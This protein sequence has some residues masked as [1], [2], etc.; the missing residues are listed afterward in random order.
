MAGIPTPTDSTASAR[1]QTIAVWAQ[2][3]RLSPAQAVAAW[4]Q[5]QAREHGGSLEGRGLRLFVDALPAVPCPAV[6]GAASDLGHLYETMLSG[7]VRKR[8][9]VH[10]TP[11]DIAGRLVGLLQPGW[12]RAG[13]GVLDP[14]VGGGAFLIAAADALVAAGIAPDTALAG[15][16]G[17]DHDSTAVAVAE[18]ALAVWQVAHDL[19]PRPLD[20]LQ[21]GDGLLD[22][23]PRC[24]IAVGNPP[25]LNQLRTVSA[26]SGTRRE[27]LRERWGDLMGA[28]TDEAW[29]F[30]AASLDAVASDGQLV[31]VQP[32]SVLAARHSEAVRR[33]LTNDAHLAGLW[34]SDGRVFDASV[35]VCAPVLRRRGAALETSG[36]AHAVPMV[37]RWRGRSFEE[38]EARPAPA[39]AGEWGRLGA[40]IAGI[41]DVDLTAASPVHRVGRAAS[42]ATVGTTV[43]DIASVTAGFRDQFYGLVPFVS[44][45]GPSSDPGAKQRRLATVGMIDPFR[46]RWGTDE[47]RF[48]G[49]RYRAPVLDVEKLEH[50]DP[51]LGRWVEARHRPKVLIATQTKVL[52]AWVDEAGGVVP[53]TPTI[54]LEPLDQHDP[55]QLWRLLAL[56]MAPAVSAEVAASCFGTALSIRALKVSARDIASLPL[57]RDRS[58]WD[59]GAKL[60]RSIQA[61][62]AADGVVDDMLAAFGEAMMHAFGLSSEDLV[63]WWRAGWPK[64]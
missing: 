22:A 39:A 28:Y 16:S 63:G 49:E 56:L 7:A 26:N 54:S 19:D 31:M 27:A 17:I 55:E 4:A 18:A 29:L 6:D 53:A 52:E 59:L 12:A 36:A 10:L 21:V 23:L 9:G 34:V 37:R 51:E 24:D 5:A 35:E 43:A 57:P 62:V 14:A 61:D 20:S 13:V 60:A 32:V 8:R 41:P 15:L 64:R 40:G 2:S 33:Q 42:G 50:E 30:L 25:F 38:I 1:V 44:D 3:H 47:F 46:F 48:A 58:A 45:A 11:A